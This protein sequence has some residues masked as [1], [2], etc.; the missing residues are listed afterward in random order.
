MKRPHWQRWLTCAYSGLR[1]RVGVFP[2]PG[3]FAVNWLG[4]VAPG[5][6]TPVPVAFIYIAAEPQHLYMYVVD[7]KN[8]DTAPTLETWERKPLLVDDQCVVFDTEVSRKP[9]AL[10]YPIPIVIPAVLDMTVDW[11]LRQC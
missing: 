2:E 8:E 9:N 5:S 3:T 10:L 11:D 4:I 6:V 1:D 7:T